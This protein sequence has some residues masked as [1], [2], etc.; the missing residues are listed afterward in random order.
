M[1]KR[2][3]LQPEFDPQAMERVRRSGGELSMGGLG[4]GWCCQRFVNRTT[5]ICS[6]GAV[7]GV[8]ARKN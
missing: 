4:D 5:L 3:K 2:K 6:M 1:S 8:C 7:L